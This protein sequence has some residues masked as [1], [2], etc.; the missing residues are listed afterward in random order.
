MGLVTEAAVSF[1]RRKM[2]GR[3][4]VRKQCSAVVMCLWL[5]VITNGLADVATAHDPKPFFVTFK[6][7]FDPGFGISVADLPFCSIFHS[8]KLYTLYLTYYVICCARQPN[9]PRF[10]VWRPC[11]GVR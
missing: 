8:L 3:S 7:N 6:A 11:A 9:L 2:S 4:C 5:P 1:H 10:N